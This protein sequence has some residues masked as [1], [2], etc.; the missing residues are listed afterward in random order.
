M[1]T[2]MNPEV[3]AEWLAALRSGDYEQGAGFLR[4]DD[5][6]YCC[7]GVL[8][9]IAE[10][11]GVIDTPELLEKTSIS[12]TYIFDYHGIDTAENS[13]LPDPVRKWAELSSDVGMLPI[14][15]E[16]GDKLSLAFLNDNG[17]SFEEIANLIEE[18]L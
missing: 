11:Y 2:K 10:T 9:A 17:T 7:L 15:D 6:K 12:Y 8:C 16:D 13:V 14:T 4:T 18:H 5:N 1:T 3:K